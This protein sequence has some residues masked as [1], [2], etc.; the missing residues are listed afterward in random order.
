MVNTFH[1]LKYLQSRLPGGAQR[2]EQ[3]LLFI[4]GS[5]VLTNSVILS[6]VR[7]GSI[8]LSHLYAP[9]VWFMVL[10]AATM[11]I[12]RFR[13]DSDPFLLPIIG[14]LSGW[15]LI[16][17]DRLVPALLPR[18]LLWFTLGLVGLTVTALLPQDLR[19]LKKYRYTLLVT[20]LVLL[21]ATFFLGC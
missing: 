1:P 14:L 11:V 18:Q 10:V 17:L 9:L 19:L 3:L 15:G 12:R 6:I 7:E 16:L 13:P 20:G 8:L 21:F 2:T 4:G 5:F